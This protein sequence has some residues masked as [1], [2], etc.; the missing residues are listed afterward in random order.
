MEMIE[1]VWGYLWSSHRFFRWKRGSSKTP[2]G[3][4]CIPCYPLGAGGA[5]V[6]NELP[7]TDDQANPHEKWDT[8]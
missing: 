2:K 6:E 5:D 4:P 1:D 7:L 8:R 3:N